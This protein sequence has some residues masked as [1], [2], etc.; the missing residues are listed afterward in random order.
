M[1]DESKTQE[2]VNKVVNAGINV[3]AFF[4]MVAI[5][6][7]L[8]AIAWTIYLSI[9]T[10]NR[11]FHRPP[12]QAEVILKAVREYEVPLQTKSTFL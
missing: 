2:K 4:R 6:L 10:L 7:V 3:S 9:F 5:L 11:F 1:G 12:T 8:A